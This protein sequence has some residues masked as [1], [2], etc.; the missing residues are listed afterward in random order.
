MF[1][2]SEIRSIGV[3]F[4][5]YK[6]IQV[7]KDILF[8]KIDNFKNSRSGYYVYPYYREKGR[9]VQN[10][11]DNK[12]KEMRNKMEKEEKMN[13]KMGD[14]NENDNDKKN[15]DNSDDLKDGEKM[16][17][18][19][20]KSLKPTINKYTRPEIGGHL[21]SIVMGRRIGYGLPF[22]ESMMRKFAKDGNDQIVEHRERKGEFTKRLRIG[23]KNCNNRGVRR[24]YNVN[25]KSSKNIGKDLDDIDKEES[26]DDD[27]DDFSSFASKDNRSTGSKEIDLADELFGDDD[28]DIILNGEEGDD[29][30]LNSSEKMLI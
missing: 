11:D 8:I 16:E 19:N 24:G 17:R 26:D 21:R 5:L 13:M 14:K 29:D 20:N 2:L 10:M 23:G 28:D 3:P 7:I 30:G 18:S 1:D 25:L 4:D 6:S 12:M 22:D 15:N 27:D 9:I